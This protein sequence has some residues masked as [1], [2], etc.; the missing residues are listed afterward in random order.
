MLKHKNKP[1]Y[2]HKYQ[3][4]II[5]P[6]ASHHLRCS[7]CNQVSSGEIAGDYGRYNSGAFFTDPDGDGY[8][9]YEC[10][11]S[12]EDQMSD[13]DLEDDYDE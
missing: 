13:Y 11:W 3:N 8:L 12:I 7:M 10:F 6:S 5:Y 9:C 1:K 4:E 2:G